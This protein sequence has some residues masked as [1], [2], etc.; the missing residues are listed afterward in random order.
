TS[1]LDALTRQA[2][3]P[4]WT[5]FGGSSGALETDCTI[6]INS[7]D[8]STAIAHATRS[9]SEI[10]RRGFRVIKTKVGGSSSALDL[11]RIEAIH[12]AAPEIA[13]TLDANGAFNASTALA[14]LADLDRRGIVPLLFEQPVATDDLA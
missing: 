14:F 1:V 10:A 8:A 12:R 13:I 2:D 4:L 5:I 6:P 9:A 11:D 3:L 7:A